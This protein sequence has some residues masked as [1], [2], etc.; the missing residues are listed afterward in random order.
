MEKIQDFM[1]LQ[2]LPISWAKLFNLSELVPV[3]KTLTPD[4][5]NARAIAQP[6][7][8]VAPVINAVFPDKFGIL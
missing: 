3:S 5:L 2:L 4:P 6:I 7:P 1:V 8:P